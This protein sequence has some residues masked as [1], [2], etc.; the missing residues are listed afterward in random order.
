MA[1]SAPY[2]PCHQDPWDRLACSDLTCSDIDGTRGMP[3][4]TWDMIRAAVL[5]RCGAALSRLPKAEAW[6]T[7]APLDQAPR[8]HHQSWSHVWGSFRLGRWYWYS[9]GGEDEHFSDLHDLNRPQVLLSPEGPRGLIPWDIP[10]PEPSLMILD[11]FIDAGL[12]VPLS[13]YERE[14]APQWEQQWEHW[15]NDQV[16]LRVQRRSQLFGT[17]SE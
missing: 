4:R 11:D 3:A 10:V 16:I 9:A 7:L 12:A 17:D 8:T 6:D 2:A 14:H 1:I 5:T 15:I 13:T